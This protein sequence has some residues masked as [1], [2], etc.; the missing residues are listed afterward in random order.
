MGLDSRVSWRRQSGRVEVGKQ[1]PVFLSF[2]A[3]LFFSYLF[4]LRICPSLGEGVEKTNMRPTHTSYS[5]LLGA[6][7]YSVFNF[8]CQHVLT[9]LLTLLLSLYYIFT[10]MMS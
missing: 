7:Q 10:L 5:G 3:L 2:F 9:L 8:N 4:F 1:N 6:C